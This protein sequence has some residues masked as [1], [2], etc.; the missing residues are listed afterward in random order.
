M[1][2]RLGKP[3]T[4][5][6]LSRHKKLTAKAKRKQ[7]VRKKYLLI[8]F[9]I[10][11]PLWLIILLYAQKLIT[12][13]LVWRLGQTQPELSPGFNPPHPFNPCDCG[14]NGLRHIQRFIDGCY[15][16]A[17]NY[18]LA[19]LSYISYADGTLENMPPMTCNRLS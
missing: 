7:R 6:K 14:R 19:S 4:T 8:P 17:I 16:N 18:K 11:A 5:F 2:L 12:P 1:F 13:S 15:S 3:L 10:F 9:A